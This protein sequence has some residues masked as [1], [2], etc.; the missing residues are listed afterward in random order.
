VKID[1]TSDEV[2]VGRSV[3]RPIGHPYSDSL[4]AH[5]VASYSI[6]ELF[7]EKLRALA[8]RC[9]PRDLY[10]VVHMHRHP[11]LIG[12]SGAVR[13]VLERKCAHAGIEVPTAAVIQ[14]SPFRAEIENEWKNMLRHQ[15]PQPLP[16]F[17]GFWAALDDVFSWLAGT[18]AV[19]ELP[20]A[21]LGKVDAWEAPR[22]IRS[23]RRGVPVELLRYAGANRLKV[24][25][26]YRA[27][28]GRHGARRVEPY[29]LR[30]TQDGNLVLFVVNDYGAL[31]RYRVDRIAGIR[32][33][34]I[35]FTPTFQVEF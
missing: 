12:L 7:G 15:L 11:D 8:E 3:L 23:W 16:P 20:R 34:A 9:R 18:L 25:I 1:L 6:T 13:R 19:R 17:E 33:T 31:R 2:I 28:Q 22:A 14:S 4:P 32:P 21:Q 24:D 29:S 10:D 27:Q 26:D 35:S 30:R 5:G